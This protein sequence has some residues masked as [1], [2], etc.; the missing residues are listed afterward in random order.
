MRD[1][2]GDDSGGNPRTRPAVPP[3]RPQQLPFTEDRDSQH[4]D[5]VPLT[6]SREGP[7]EEP[8]SYAHEVSDPAPA[9]HTATPLDGPLGLPAQRPTFC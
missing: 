9:Q 5:L 4:S 6:G 8:A 7:S 3:A 2:L 1:A